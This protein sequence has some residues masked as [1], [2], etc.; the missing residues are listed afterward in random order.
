MEIRLCLMLER[1]QQMSN[2][3]VVFVVVKVHLLFFL[4]GCKIQPETHWVSN[5]CT[6]QHNFLQ[7]IVKLTSDVKQRMTK[8]TKNVETK[9][10]RKTTA[11]KNTFL[12]VF[13]PITSLVC[14]L[15]DLTYSSLLA[16][17]HSSILNDKS[18]WSDLLKHILT[19]NKFCTFCIKVTI[20]LRY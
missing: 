7:V 3:L 9:W 15:T 6:G 17:R 8:T 5:W 20:T 16:G 14:L 19:L 2:Y 1:C 12:Q 11:S 18:S 4:S 10:N 13:T